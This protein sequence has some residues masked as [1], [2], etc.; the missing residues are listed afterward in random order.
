MPLI[1][2]S[3]FPSSAPSEVVERLRATGDAPRIAWIPPDT[4]GNH[5]HFDEA[6]QRFSGLGFDRLEPCDIDRE[7]D[8]V[9]LAYLYEFDVIYLS[10]GD[11]VRFRFNMFRSGLS[12][13]LRR[14]LAAGRLVVAASAGSLLLTPNVS[15][16]RLQTE[17]LETVLADRSRFDAM[18]AVPY[19]LL[20][21]ANRA[22]AALWD[23]VRRYSRQVENDIVALPDGGALFDAGDS[24]AAIGE[25]ARYRLGVPVT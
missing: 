3:D 7:K 18:S 14:C 10:G 1:L 8:D 4:E 12:H 20:P 24:F 11:P 2:T 13:Q 25:V 23:K 9:Q 16:F 21:H 5:A 22:D 15:I 6:R 17:P 19:E